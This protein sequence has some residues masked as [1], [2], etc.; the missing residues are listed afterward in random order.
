V[1]GAIYSN[2]RDGLLLKKC[3]EESDAIPWRAFSDYVTVGEKFAGLYLDA[4]RKRGMQIKHQTAC[5]V[6]YMP[7]GDAATVQTPK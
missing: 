3:L 2:Q 6:V 7:P 1:F 4:L 5:A